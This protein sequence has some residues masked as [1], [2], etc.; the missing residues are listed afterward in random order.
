MTTRVSKPVVRWVPLAALRCG[1]TTLIDHH[2]SPNVI[3]GSLDALQA[4]MRQ[5][6]VRGVLCYETTNRNRADEARQGLAENE[7]FIK[8]CLATKDGHFAGMVGAHASFTLNDDD[9]ANCVDLARQLASGVHLH[10]AEDPVDERLTRETY[11]CGLMERFA[12]CGLLETAGS[13]IAHGTHFSDA[14]LAVIN[15]HDRCLA[16]AHNPNSNM[17]NGVGYAPVAKL[18]KAPLLGTDG[19]G[20]DMWREAR[21]ALFKSNDAHRSI[22][23]ERPLQMMARSAAFASEYLGI[24]LGNL[25][26]GSAADMIITNYQPATPLSVE[27]LAGH[28]IFGMGAEFVR[29]VLIGGEWCLRDGVVTT[30]DERQLCANAVEIAKNLYARM[31]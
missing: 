31:E 17:N 24:R 7:R 1:T 8:K 30:C 13:I 3:D 23:Y 18:T 2:A 15:D 26:P 25:Q 21:T 28:L 9:L 6:G 5:V 16:V 27:N 10:A 20:A 22:G 12:K 4:G 29:H 14:D 11:G 19:I